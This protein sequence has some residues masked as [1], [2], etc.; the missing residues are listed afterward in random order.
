MIQ[1]INLTRMDSISQD[2]GSKLDIK[3]GNK[4]VPKNY[5]IHPTYL[6]LA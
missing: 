4:R 6:T 5:A 1:T 2:M 3:L